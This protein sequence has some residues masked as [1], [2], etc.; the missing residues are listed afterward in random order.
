[1]RGEILAVAGG[2]ERP[3]GHRPPDQRA[4]GVRARCLPCHFDADH[5]G[6]R[7]RGARDGDKVAVEIRSRGTRQ[8]D[9]RVAVTMRLVPA[10]RPSAAPKPCCMTGMSMSVS[11]TRCGRKPKSWRAHRS[12]RRIPPAGW[13]C[14]PCPSLPSTAPETKDI[15][16]AISLNQTPDGFELGVHIAD[17]SHYVKPGTE[18]DNEA[19]SRATSVY[20]A[21]QVVPM[22]PKQ[23]SNGI[24]SLNEG[25]AASGFLLSDAPGQDGQ[26]G[27]LQVRQVGDPQAGSRACTARSTPCWL[28]PP[29]PSY[30]TNTPRW[31]PSC[32]P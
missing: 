6:R 9:H 21:D 13:T 32:L 12:P 15:D 8:E 23:L 22:L 3:G 26:P 14:G 5:P 18:L 20:Y 11:P 28:A 4:S 19:F 10:R 2:K 24:C 30:S 1:M 7:G 16:D 27:G 17:V 29:T 31:L 25:G